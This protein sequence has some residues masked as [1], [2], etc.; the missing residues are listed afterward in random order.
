MKMPKY[1]FP[2]S[3]NNQLRQ[4]SGLERVEES[5]NE[6][7]D[8]IYDQQDDI[9][10]KLAAAEAAAEQAGEYAEE[11]FSGTPE[12]YD[13]LV[14]DVGDLKNAVDKQKDVIYK[15]SSNMLDFGFIGSTWEQG[16]IGNANPY[17]CKTKK[18]SVE[19]GEKLYGVVN[20]A[21]M[22]ETSALSTFTMAMYV[23]FF[24]DG[25]EQI[26]SAF[27]I[28]NSSGQETGSVDIPINCDYIIVVLSTGS[29]ANQFTPSTLDNAVEAFAYIGYENKSYTEVLPNYVPYP[30]YNDEQIQTLTGE[31]DEIEEKISNWNGKKIVWFG[32]SIPAGVVN[33]G[34]IG[35]NGS[36]PTRIGKMLGATVYNESVGSSCARGGSH[37]DITEGDPMGW[38]GM[39]VLAIMYSLSLSSSEKQSFIDDWETKWKDVVHEPSAFDASKAAEYKASSWD[40]K[41]SKYLTGGSIGQCDLYVIDHGYNENVYTYGYTDLEDEPETANDRTYFYGALDFIV[42][43]ILND[44]PKAHILLIG[45]YSKGDYQFS[46]GE[47]FCMKYVCDAQAKY[48]D[49]WGITCIPTWNLLG[50]TSQTITV[51]GEDIS[52]IAARYPDKLHPASDLTGMELKRYAEAL[53]PYVNMSAGT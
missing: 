8:Y 19:A 2:T 48:A 18:I 26:G 14:A 5:L 6:I 13:T 34:D 45:H 39:H 24:T 21:K 25:D 37:K 42:R 32:T 51:N 20:G 31:V 28:S 3:R 11:A 33:A 43:K 4:G 38:G 50:L 40:V 17:M 30:A 27:N 47:N 35:G 1:P 49:R 16:G 10:T 22:A 52:V 46:G 41:L 44:N 12:G 36:Y 23:A 7:V 15:K 9:N 29:W 53:A